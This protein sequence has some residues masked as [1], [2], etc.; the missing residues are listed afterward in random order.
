MSIYTQCKELYN[1]LLSKTE[2]HFKKLGISDIYINEFIMILTIC[3]THDINIEYPFYELTKISNYMKDD[4]NLNIKTIIAIILQK[5]LINKTPLEILYMLNIQKNFNKDLQDFMIAKM[6]YIFNY[7]T[8]CS[9]IELCDIKFVMNKKIIDT[10]KIINDVDVI[11]LL[12]LF[13]KKN[14]MNINNIKLFIDNKEMYITN[15]LIEYGITYENNIIN[16]II[17]QKS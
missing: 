5:H 16:V 14:N 15:K 6:K 1:E 11:I 8:I 2:Q 7:N 4:S 13:C 9:K 12:E 10:I 17:L 3:V